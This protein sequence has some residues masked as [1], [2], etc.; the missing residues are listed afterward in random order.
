MKRILFLLAMALAISVPAQK[1]VSKTIDVLDLP[2]SF[3]QVDGIITSIETSSIVIHRTIDRTVRPVDTT[4]VYAFSPAS[5]QTT[6]FYSLNYWD[7]RMR[8]NPTISIDDFVDKGNGT[9]VRSMFYGA[10]TGA[11]HPGITYKIHSPELVSEVRNI[12]ENVSIVR[13]RVGLSTI[14]NPVNTLF[15]NPPVR[16]TVLTYHKSTKRTQLSS[17]GL[18]ETRSLNEILVGLKMT[19]SEL[20]ER[21]SAKYII[22]KRGDNHIHSSCTEAIG[23]ASS[24]Y[25]IKSYY[26]GVDIA[27]QR[28]TGKITSYNK[29]W[30]GVA[31]RWIIYN[32]I[33]NHGATGATQVIEYRTTLAQANALPLR[34]VPGSSYSYNQSSNTVTYNS[35]VPCTVWAVTEEMPAQYKQWQTETI[36][37]VENGTLIRV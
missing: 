12:G 1:N 35:N 20:E 11:W 8:G 9:F 33:N 18:S 14:Q 4:E 13:Q 26:D 36:Y 28:P 19:R 21:L 31:Q 10:L 23:N 32:G 29:Q 24:G 27:L 15:E 30:P 25:L 6:S 37:N 16:V 5:A 3:E 2:A 7:G 34:F 22:T 17:R